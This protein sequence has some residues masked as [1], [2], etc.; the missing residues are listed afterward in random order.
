MKTR[1]IS[2]NAAMVNHFIQRDGSILNVVQPSEISKTIRGNFQYYDAFTGTIYILKINPGKELD[3]MQV[4]PLAQHEPTYPLYSGAT[5]VL[6]NG[7]DLFIFFHDLIENSEA[8]P[9]QAINTVVLEGQ[10]PAARL[11]A[12]HINENGSLNR[13]RIE[14]IAGDG[15]KF[16]PHRPFAIYDGEVIYTLCHR[17]SSTK[18]THKIISVNLRQ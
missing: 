13:F 14:N 3:W 15:H 16:A 1:G 10:W 2:A 8:Q 17:R 11:T 18:S 4:I 12:F 5:A 9:N 6:D 7:K